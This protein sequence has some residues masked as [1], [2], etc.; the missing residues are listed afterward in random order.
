MR[1]PSSGGIGKRLNR[2]AHEI[3]NHVD[4]STV[5]QC[6]NVAGKLSFAH[7]HS[8]IEPQ[9]L[10]ALE[11]LVRASRAD[12]PRASGSCDPQ[13]SDPHT[14]A[15]G[16]N[17]STF[18]VRES[19][20][21]HHRVVSGEVGL[22][23]RGCLCER[24]PVRD[25]RGSG[26]RND[27]VLGIAAAANEAVDAV[28]L[29]EVDDA[30]PDTRH[31]P[32]VLEA[33]NVRRNAGR[34]RVTAHALQKICAIDRRGAN[35]HQDLSIAW[36]RRIVDRRNDK[37]FWTARL[38]YDDG[39]HEV[40][41]T[42]LLSRRNAVEDAEIVFSREDTTLATDREVATGVRPRDVD[43]ALVVRVEVL[44]VLATGQ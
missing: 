42:P 36:W 32:R 16:M 28:A 40:A 18:A 15:H 10:R 21:H 23:D 31:L 14:T 34:S 9:Q 38:A 41:F 2:P 24:Q 4:A 8:L 12:G 5:S 13:G 43:A 35:T 20:L 26:R 37:Y 27:D 39:F 19:G 25:T 44:T 17:E 1:L 30:L 6:L 7:A 3:E 29:D 11:L 22:G 33:E